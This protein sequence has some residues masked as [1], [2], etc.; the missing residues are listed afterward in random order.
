MRPCRREFVRAIDAGAKQNSSAAGRDAFTRLAEL[1]RKIGDVF[2]D[3]RQTH[4]P[5]NV[6]RG[7]CRGHR[8]ERLLRQVAGET[9]SQAIDG[10]DEPLLVRC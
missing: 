4:W 8:S 6:L 1:V 2:R 3:N 10:R 9:I 5:A 7:K